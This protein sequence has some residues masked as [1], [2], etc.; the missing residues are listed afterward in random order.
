[1]ASHRA[2][3]KLSTARFDSKSGFLSFGG[4]D[5]KIHRFAY[6]FIDFQSISFKNEF[7]AAKMAYRKDFP[8]RKDLILT[9]PCRK[10]LFLPPYRCP[11]TIIIPAGNPTPPNVTAKRRDVR[12]KLF[13]IAPQK[14]G[15][16]ANSGDDDC[17]DG[18]LR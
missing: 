7:R 14:A 16:N 8:Y 13:A 18:S 4:V 12:T 6:T 1:M 9:A 3:Q 15:G 10:D 17:Y 2:S 11:A 5:T